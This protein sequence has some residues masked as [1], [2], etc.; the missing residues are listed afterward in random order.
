[1]MK[2]KI[3]RDIENQELEDLFVDGIIEENKTYEVEEFS[4]RWV[5]VKGHF[6]HNGEYEVVK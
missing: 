6:V 3:I 2:V 4:P 1:M 5:I